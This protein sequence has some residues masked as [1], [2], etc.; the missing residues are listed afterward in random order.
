MFLVS[1][2]KA[3]RVKIVLIQERGRWA[4]DRLRLEI[5]LLAGQED[6]SSDWSK[7]R[8]HFHCIYVID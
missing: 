1:Q 7:I 3:V 5:G 4:L 6:K 8:F 2:N